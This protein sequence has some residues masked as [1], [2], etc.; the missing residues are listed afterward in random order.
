MD[1]DFE[2]VNVE[3]QPV[4]DEGDGAELHLQVSK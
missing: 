4:Q 1:P 3:G 2:F